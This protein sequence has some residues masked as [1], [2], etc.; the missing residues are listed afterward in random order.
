MSKHWPFVNPQTLPDLPVQ[1]WAYYVRA[2]QAIVEAARDA[3]QGV[4]K[5][6][7]VRRRSRV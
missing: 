2:A 6:R 4:D 1:W 7:D 3:R 5:V